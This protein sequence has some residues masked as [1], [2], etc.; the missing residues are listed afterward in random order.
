MMLGDA[1]HRAQVKKTY[2]FE[3]WP[4]PAASPARPLPL[5]PTADMTLPFLDREPMA[6]GYVDNYGTSDGILVSVWVHQYGSPEAAQE[7]L[8]DFLV[9]SMSVRLPLGSERDLDLGD[10]SIAGHTEE[11]LS[12]AFVRN[13]MFVRVHSGGDQDYPVLE[14][15]RI[16]DEIMR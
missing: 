2:G 11:H 9:D 16:V 5:L 1:E 14:I 13:E 15:A 6:H 4:R 7:A 12:L 8:I 10:I 3:N